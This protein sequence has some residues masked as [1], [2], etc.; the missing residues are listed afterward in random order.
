MNFTDLLARGSTLVR[1]RDASLVIVVNACLRFQRQGRGGVVYGMDSD[2]SKRQTG[3]ATVAHPPVRLC[4]DPSQ[5]ARGYITG[6][7]APA[8]KPAND[9]RPMVPLMMPMP[10]MMKLVME[11]A[12]G[13]A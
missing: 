3:A 11:S 13:F 2:D 8:S 10:L 7:I 12:S 5:A 1:V 4:A 6:P 9:D